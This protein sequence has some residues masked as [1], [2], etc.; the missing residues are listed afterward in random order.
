MRLGL[1]FLS[2]LIFTNN[3]F[4]EAKVAI[5]IDDIGYTKHSID[6][7]GELDFPITASIFPAYNYSEF[8]AKRANELGLEVIIHMPMEPERKLNPGP[9]AIYQKMSNNEIR[10]LVK[11]NIETVPFAIG[12]NN[13][14]GS[15]ITK[16]TRCMNIILSETKKRGLIFIDSLVVHN[17]VCK[18]AAKK[19]GFNILKRDVFLDNKDDLNYIKGQLRQLMNIALKTGKAIGIGHI[20]REYTIQAIREMLPVMRANGVSFCYVS[21]I[22]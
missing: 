17:S 10:T 7:L 19:L 13:H 9:G 2:I 8:L 16:D 15:K 6:V 20:D 11:N 1:F 5:I 18:N 3:L 21:E 22:F 12:M 14:M 4:A